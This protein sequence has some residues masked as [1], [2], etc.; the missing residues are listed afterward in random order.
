MAANYEL[1]CELHGH[2]EDIRAVCVVDDNVF[3]TASR[4]KT[5]K[6]WKAEGD[7]GFSPMTTLVGHTHFVTALAWMKP[8]TDPRFPSGTVVSGSRDKKVIAWDIYT[9][10][11]VYEMEGHEQQVRKT[12]RDQSQY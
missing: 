7:L 6:I 10:A 8:S 1:R 4:D 11:P 2:E 3:A 12:S 9:G 5:V